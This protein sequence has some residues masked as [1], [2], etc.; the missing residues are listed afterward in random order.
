[1]WAISVYDGSEA[2]TQQYKCVDELSIE[3]SVC[4]RFRPRWHCF[5][6]IFKCALIQMREIQGVINLLLW[7]FLYSLV[8]VAFFY[9][10]LQYIICTILATAE[11]VAS[12]SLCNFNF[13]ILCYSKV[14]RQNSRDYFHLCVWQPMP[15]I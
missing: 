1:M 3:L 13:F 10:P 9:I 6:N 2:T 8:G 11:R 4:A 5:V 15:K 12:E 14:W 7:V